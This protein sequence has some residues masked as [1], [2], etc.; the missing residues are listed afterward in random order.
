MAASDRQSDEEPVVTAAAVLA[1]RRAAGLGPT[2]PVARRVVIPL[3]GSVFGTLRERPFHEAMRAALGLGGAPGG[4]RLGIDL[5]PPPGVGGPAM[6]ALAEELGARGA[7]ELVTV[8]L[9]GGI[10]GSTRSGSVV[11]VDMALPHDGVSAAYGAGPEP[12]MADR[13]LADEVASRLAKAGIAHERG[14]TWTTDAVYRETPTQIRAAVERGAGVVEM[15]IAGLYTVAGAVGLSAV[16]VVIV[17]DTI[18]GSSWQPPVD[19]A[20]CRRSMVAVAR[21]LLAP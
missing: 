4:S 14:T 3:D 12:V 5:A 15:E 7:R 19:L 18:S 17:A 10:G 6:A 13:A 2:A 20:A 11:V 9:A 1:W 16:A 21:S 8:G